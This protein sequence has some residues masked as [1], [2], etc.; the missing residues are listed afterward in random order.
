MKRFQTTILMVL[1]IL[2][3]P[4]TGS[5]GEE[6]DHLIKFASL[7]PEGSTW[8]NVMRELDADVREATDGQVGFKI[9]AGG[10]QGDEPDVLRKIRFGQLHGA[11]FTGN[12]MGEI[13]PETRVL[14]LPFLYR[15]K[16]EIDYILTEL[17]DHFDQAFRE[18]GFVLLGW[19]DVGYVYFYSN[20][21]LRTM[22]DLQGAKVWTWQGDE[23][24]AA[25]FD[26]LGIT[27]IPLS[28]TE[29]MT[30]LQTGMVDAVYTVPMAAI[31]LQWFTRVE[32]M[33]LGE[34][35]NTMG[36]VVMSRKIFDRLTPQQQASLLEIS[37]ARLRELSLLTRQD[38]AESIQVLEEAGV[39][40]LPPPNEE[41]MAEYQAVGERVRERLVGELYPRELLDRV[42]A[43]LQEYRSTES[44]EEVAPQATSETEAE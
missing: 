6:P 24:A 44:N 35:T 7:A 36:A 26:E 39:E 10:V 17:T 19:V 25:L 4:C 38:N 11:G 43:L 1:S 18:K 13:L 15:D 41:Q 23:L 28:V 22:A 9:Y 27:P 5:A 37:R 3:L 12:G 16:D 21:P 29:V 40:L 33:N 2:I 8:M 34:L 14:E 32:Y 42:E 30:A 31:S 20:T